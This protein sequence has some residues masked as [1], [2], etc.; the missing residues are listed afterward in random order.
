MPATAFAAI[1]PFAVVFGG[2]N[3]QTLVVEIKINVF[4]EPLGR[5]GNR[6]VHTGL[7]VINASR[8][9]ACRK[10]IFEGKITL[11]AQN[12]TIAHKIFGV[13]AVQQALWIS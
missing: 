12:H 7:A 13:G 2:E 3:H 10:R 11:I 4:N 6:S 5:F 9:N 1:A 8:G